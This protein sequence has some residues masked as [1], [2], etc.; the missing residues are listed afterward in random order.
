MD[1]IATVQVSDIERLSM[2]HNIAVKPRHEQDAI[3][4]DLLASMWAYKERKGLM[5]KPDIFKFIHQHYPNPELQEHLI[6]RYE[7]FKTM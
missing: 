6:K 7:F 1:I 5:S 4:H 3:Q 2:S